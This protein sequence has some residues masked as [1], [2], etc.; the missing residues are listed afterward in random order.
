MVSI[1]ILYAVHNVNSL[2]TWEGKLTIH[3]DTF[4]DLGCIT[5]SIVTTRVVTGV[6]RAIDSMDQSGD[7]EAHPVLHHCHTIPCAH[8]GEHFADKGAK[9]GHI[10]DHT[11]ETAAPRGVT[12]SQCATC[13]GDGG[14]RLDVHW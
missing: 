5:W 1:I 2:G 3:E 10:G 14:W 12:T 4:A 6:L 13:D 11:R 8:H 7:T 9:V